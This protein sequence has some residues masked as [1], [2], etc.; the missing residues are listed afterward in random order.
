MSAMPKIEEIIGAHDEFSATQL[1][2]LDIFERHPDYL[3]RTTPEDLSQIRA[4][5]TN[6]DA[7]APP[8]RASQ[9]DGPLHIKS[10]KSSMKVR[11]KEG[12]IASLLIH[13][14]R[15]FGSHEAVKRAR[16]ALSKTA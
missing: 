12:K 6:P 1:R 2:V 3:F 8:Q 7:K 16:A 5:S 15:F 4:W 13:H 10:I 9:D 14:E 11:Y